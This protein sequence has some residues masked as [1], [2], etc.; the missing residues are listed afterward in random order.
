MDGTTGG[1][2]LSLCHR[3]G[4]SG[5]LTAD[6]AAT[7][8]HSRPSSGLISKP[9]AS[10]TKLIERLDLFA[11]ASS[12]TFPPSRAEATGGSELHA[13]AGE[14]A[15]YRTS[16]AGRERTSLMLAGGPANGEHYGLGRGLGRRGVKSVT[17]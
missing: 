2:S 10:Q 11:P 7:V 15:V 6:Y 17:A 8:L 3:D 1:T 13:S 9:R 5:Q 14:A 4:L 12:T 16:G